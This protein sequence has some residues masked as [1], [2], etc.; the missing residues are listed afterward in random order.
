MFKVLPANRGW[1]E[2]ICGCMF[3]GKTEELI[4]RIRRA[5]IARQS[6]IVFKPGI[7]DRYN[8]ED[9]VSHNQVS[10]P[11][12]AVETAAEIEQLAGDHQVIGIDEIQFIK[13][14]TVSVVRRLANHGRRV[15]IAG[16]D[17]DYRGFL[18]NRYLS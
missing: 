4:R 2:V 8:R 11:S 12:V 10:I 9:V 17:T 5:K 7:D 1:I 13:G 3:S 16:L 18:S 14:D 6:V 15:I